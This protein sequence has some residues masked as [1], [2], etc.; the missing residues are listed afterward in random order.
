MVHKAPKSK[1][2][3]ITAYAV[4]DIIVT[5][6]FVNLDY[7]VEA[8]V[9]KIAQIIYTT[10]VGYYDVVKSFLQKFSNSFIVALIVSASS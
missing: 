10:T 4:L 2:N 5:A 1:S 7:F 9:H 8:I 6:F 3:A